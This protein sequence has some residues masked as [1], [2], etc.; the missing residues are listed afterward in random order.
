MTTGKVSARRSDVPLGVLHPLFLGRRFDRPGARP[1]HTPDGLS[2]R[3]TSLDLQPRRDHAGPAKP[4]PT[5]D[6][7][8]AL[9]IENIA[10]RAGD[11]R[12]VRVASRG[13]VV[14][15]RKA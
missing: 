3:R 2:G 6:E 10:D 11:C 9:A 8:P 13:A 15:D 12:P 14:A 1:S 4:T 7:N 5:M